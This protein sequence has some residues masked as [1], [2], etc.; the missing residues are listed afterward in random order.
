[1]KA[2][3]SSPYF[4]LFQDQDKSKMSITQKPFIRNFFELKIIASIVA[5]KSCSNVTVFTV[6]KMCDVI[7]LKNIFVCLLLAM[8]RK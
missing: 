5:L 7:Q 4:F 2:H 1:M 3:F 6:N 8:K